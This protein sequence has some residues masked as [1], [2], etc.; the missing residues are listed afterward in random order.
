MLRRVLGM[1][2]STMP[3][4]V[5]FYIFHTSPMSVRMREAIETSGMR[6]SLH[7]HFMPRPRWARASSTLAIGAFSPYLPS[8]FPKAPYFAIG[9]VGLV[10]DWDRIPLAGGPIS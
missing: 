5:V 4:P 1:A 6:V 2:Q 8:Y 10:C 3:R 9:G 7:P